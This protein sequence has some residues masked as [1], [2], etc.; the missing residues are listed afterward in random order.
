[1]KDNLRTNEK[2]KEMGRSRTMIQQNEK[3][4]TAHISINIMNIMNDLT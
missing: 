1:M 4:S 2:S 3:K